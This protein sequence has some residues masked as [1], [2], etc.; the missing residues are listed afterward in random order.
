MM[1][2]FLLGW[3]GGGGDRSK[4]YYKQ[5]V[6]GR[7]KRFQLMCFV[8]PIQGNLSFHELCVQM[9]ADRAEE[10]VLSVSLGKYHTV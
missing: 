7:N 4:V 5:C 10:K 6:S 1:I 9:V 8:L 3:I 2:P